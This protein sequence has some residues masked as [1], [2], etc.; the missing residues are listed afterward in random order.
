VQIAE[1]AKWR[2]VFRV[3]ASAGEAHPE[4]AWTQYVK[5]NVS[6]IPMH[7]SKSKGVR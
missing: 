7:L 1:T 4:E 5:W 3:M 6:I 2:A